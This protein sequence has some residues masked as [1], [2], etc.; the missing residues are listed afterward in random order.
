[1]NV[2]N[3]SFIHTFI[4][5]MLFMSKI[6]LTLLMLALFAGFGR[7]HAQVESTAFRLMLKGMLSHNVPETSAKKVASDDRKTLFLDARAWRE[8]EVSHLKDAV[9]VG[10]DDFSFDRIPHISKD[11]KIVVYCAV[12]YRSEKISEKLIGAGYTNVSNMVGGI[13]EWSNE[14][15][16]LVDC[17]DNPTREVH[18]YDKIWG[19]V[20]Q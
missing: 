17:D 13:F 9:W 20:D 14:E 3:T 11:E 15:L 8:Y 12:G 6:T 2:T 4:W 1:M 10:Y 5:E 18:A 19:G 7:L 16:P